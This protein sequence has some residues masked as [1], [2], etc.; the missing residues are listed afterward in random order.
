MNSYN[1]GHNNSCKKIRK[2]DKIEYYIYKT[3]TVYFHFCTS[4]YPLKLFFNVL[5][6][7]FPCNFGTQRT[8]P[9]SALLPPSFLFSSSSSMADWLMWK[10][11]SG[12]DKRRHSVLYVLVELFKGTIC[13]KSLD[14]NYFDQ[15]ILH[16]FST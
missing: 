11:V 7:V 6:C 8:L 9:C 13:T 5:L 3:T 12:W 16:L 4:S 14:M 2:Y 15:S 1:I 10:C